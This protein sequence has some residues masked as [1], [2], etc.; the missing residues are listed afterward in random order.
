[1][2]PMPPMHHR[3]PTRL[4]RRAPMPLMRRALDR[5]VRSVRVRSMR[6]VLGWPPW[7][8]GAAPAPTS[9]ALC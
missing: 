2:P 4:M 1:M 7:P 5:A 3:A 8:R 6:S 9:A